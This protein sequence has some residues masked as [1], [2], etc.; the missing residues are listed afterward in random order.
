MSCCVIKR[1]KANWPPVE[2]LIAAVIKTSYRKVGADLGVTD[3]AVKK[4]IKRRLGSAPAKQ[5]PRN[6]S[7]KE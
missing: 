2:E 3:N 6:P 7:I 1:A 5:K 4:Y